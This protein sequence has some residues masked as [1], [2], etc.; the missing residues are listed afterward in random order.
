MIGRIVCGV[1]VVALLPVL[2]G[3]GRGNAILE[4]AEKGDTKTVE[5]LLKKDPSLVN[6]QRFG[7]GWSPLLLAVG[8]GHAR[9]V[10]L[11]LEA[12]APLEDRAIRDAAAGGHIDIVEMFLAKGVDVNGPPDLMEGAA[13][14]GSTAMVQWLLAKGVSAQRKP[15]SRGPLQNA[16]YGGHK[17]VA[18]ILLAHGARADD[19]D[20]QGGTPLSGAAYVGSTDIAELLIKH[21]AKVNDSTTKGITPLMWAADSHAVGTVKLLLEHGADVNARDSNQNTALIY[22]IK[23]RLTGIP[24]ERA[25]I[26]RLGGQSSK[27]NGKEVWVMVLKRRRAAVVE[28]LLAHGADANAQNQNQDTVSTLAM[29]KDCLSCEDV[30]QLL[31]QR[32]RV[33]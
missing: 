18:E 1:A 22:A 19:K 26:E 12:G 29:K 32:G 5:R 11:L 9:I 2:A 33:Q 10:A 14:G 30:L 3:C 15:G 7:P 21:G 8:G 24:E 6:A 25:E 27:K 23:R 17:A 16:A 20:E 13:T 28:L 31:A 4:A